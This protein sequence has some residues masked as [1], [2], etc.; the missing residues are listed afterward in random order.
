MTTLSEIFQVVIAFE[1]TFYL[2]IAYQWFRNEKWM[3]CQKIDK[4]I[5]CSIVIG[6]CY[7]G[8]I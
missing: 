5:L 7:I 8:N 6:S 4:V 3:S 1:L 2:V